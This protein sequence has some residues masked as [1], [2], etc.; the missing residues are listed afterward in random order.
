MWL[1]WEEG[2]NRRAI[3]PTRNTLSYWYWEN[4]EDGEGNPLKAGYLFIAC[5]HVH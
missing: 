5:F 3:L 4:G 2:L 1:V